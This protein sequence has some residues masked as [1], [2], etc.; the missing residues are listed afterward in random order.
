L[1]FGNRQH[2]RGTGADES[3]FRAQ[4]SK[5]CIMQCLRPWQSW[6]PQQVC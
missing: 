1:R 3:A 6:F 4:E 2:A 5:E